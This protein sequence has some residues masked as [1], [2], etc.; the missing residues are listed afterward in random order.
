VLSR[1]CVYLTEAAGSLVP[2]LCCGSFENKQ[3]SN[4]DA[5]V[6]FLAFQTSTNADKI[7]DNVLRVAGIQ[8]VASNVPATRD[9]C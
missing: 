3:N 5:C 9:T 6:R 4:T 7:M 2:C 8:L 1:K